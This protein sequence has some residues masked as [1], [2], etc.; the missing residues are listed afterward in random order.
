[1]EKAPSLK[2]LTHALERAW[3]VFKAALAVQWRCNIMYPVRALWSVCSARDALNRCESYVITR[4]NLYKLVF[5]SA[6]SL[7]LGV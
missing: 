4:V 3:L 6:A 5:Y 2:G 7:L 1:M